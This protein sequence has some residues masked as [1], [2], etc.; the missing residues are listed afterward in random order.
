LNINVPKYSVIC[1]YKNQLQPSTSLLG[2]SYTVFTFIRRVIC[3]LEG[4]T[5]SWAQS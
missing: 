2:G 4:V 1:S 3:T 5:V